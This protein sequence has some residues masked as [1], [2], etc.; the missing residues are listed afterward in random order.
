M[1][2]LSWLWLRWQPESRTTK[3]Y[4]T[5]VGKGGSRAKRKAIVAVARKLLVEFW[6]F[7]EHGVV[8]TGAVLKTTDAERQA[9]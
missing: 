7:V 6:H 2:E 8:P 3:W 9:A 5:H 1:V 4:H